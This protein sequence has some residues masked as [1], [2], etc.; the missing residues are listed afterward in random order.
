[1]KGNENTK[2]RKTDEGKWIYKNGEK[3]SLSALFSIMVMAWGAT[4]TMKIA[5]I[6]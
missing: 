2:Q 3:T 4:P 6:R 1:M 5:I